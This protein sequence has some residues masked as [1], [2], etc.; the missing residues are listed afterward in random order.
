VT[1]RARWVTLRARWVT[2]RARWVTLRARWVTL[3]A[4]WVT[5]RARWVT[6]TY[7]WVRLTYHWV[8]LDAVA[9]PRVGSSAHAARVL[10]P[11]CVHTLAAKTPLLA[12]PANTRAGTLP[13]PCCVGAWVVVAPRAAGVCAE[14]GG[15]HQV[16]P[17]LKPAH[18]AKRTPA[19]FCFAQASG[20]DGA[21]AGAGRGGG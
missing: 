5:L 21:A 8:T 13:P 20:S 2:L 14:E 3:R 16:D 6:L 1:L 12:N 11:R 10:S 15:R 18:H 4:R 9:A 17:N 19:R 7:R